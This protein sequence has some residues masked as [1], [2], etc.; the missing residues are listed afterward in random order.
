M[1]V[2]VLVLW[3]HGSYGCLRSPEN[4]LFGVSALGP[5]TLNS[6]AIGSLAGVEFGGQEKVDPTDRWAPGP[7]RLIKLAF[8]AGLDLGGA[9]KSQMSSCLVSSLPRTC[10]FIYF[11]L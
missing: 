4:P 2:C 5:G 9:L 8:P 1:V 10:T 3:A 11:S 6:G 7:G